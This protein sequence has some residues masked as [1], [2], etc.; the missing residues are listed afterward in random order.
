MPKSSSDEPDAEVAQIA[1]A[2]SMLARDSSIRTALGDLQLEPVRRAG[3][4]A[5]RIAATSPTRSGCGE[6]AG[7]Q[8]DAH[9]RAASRAARVPRAR[10]GGTPLEDPAADR[11][12]QA[13]LLG[14][15][16]ER[17]R[18]DQPARRVLPADAAPRRRRSR[19]SPGRRSA[20]SGAAARRARRRRRRSFSSSSRS[21]WPRVMLG[22]KTSCRPGVG[23]RPVRAM[24]ASRS[25]S[26]GRP[27]RPAPWRCRCWR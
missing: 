16:D 3:P 12:D 8:V 4:V 9:R 26:P 22:S 6:L 18:R 7:R 21:T 15:R 5:C 2:T 17:E 11:H 19:R 10:P 23:L 27:G 14:Q 20:G 13:G 1:G 25:S 24:S